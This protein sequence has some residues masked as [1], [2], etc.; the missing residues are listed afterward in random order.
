MHIFGA[1]F[2]SVQTSATLHM[3]RTMFPVELT[4]EEIECKYRTEW[5]QEL[6]KMQTALVT[7]SDVVQDSVRELFRL[8]AMWYLELHRKP[9]FDVML[10]AKV[11]V[12]SHEI[13]KSYV[14]RLALLADPQFR[15][16]K[17][18]E[19]KTTFE[20]FVRS[21]GYLPFEKYFDVLVT[22][23]TW[24]DRG[25]FLCR[26]LHRAKSSGGS[27]KVFYRFLFGS[28]TVCMKWLHM[29]CWVC[30]DLGVKW[31]GC[32]NRIGCCD[33][34]FRDWDR[35]FPSLKVV[36]GQ[37]E[38]HRLEIVVLHVLGVMT[39]DELTK[40]AVV[41][42]PRL[43]LKHVNMKFSLVDVVDG[44]IEATLKDSECTEAKGF[45]MEMA[46][47]RVLQTACG[48]LL[49]GLDHKMVV[50]DALEYAMQ[51]YEHVVVTKQHLIAKQ[52]GGCVGQKLR[53][54]S[55][56]YL[57]HMLEDERGWGKMIKSGG[58]DS[59]ALCCMECRKKWH[60]T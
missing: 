15:V 23:T 36:C 18:L 45:L 17:L 47:L 28:E 14:V 29:T 12:L 59:E 31:L 51:K 1:N 35:Q 58:S 48:R 21:D 52:K 8:A 30:L 34:L 19:P 9:I 10:T 26:T 40:G 38:L 60:S 11:M 44:D 20:F 57:E 56:E 46:M 2:G 43:N 33:F 55:V 25:E 27:Q 53:T 42:H 49:C 4:D 54:F 3:P 24:L 39:C 16:D 6:E 37:D 13:F 32:G 41:I 5:Q 7:M 22:C 50:D